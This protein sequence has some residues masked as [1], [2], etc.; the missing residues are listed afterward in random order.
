LHH[1]LH[2]QRC[3]AER[4]RPRPGADHYYARTLSLPLYPALPPADVTRV[5][6]ELHRVLGESS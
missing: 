3:P 4:A 5:V 6:G 1:A 2:A